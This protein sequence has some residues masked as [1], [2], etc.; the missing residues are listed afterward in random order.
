MVSS[1]YLLPSKYGGTL[2][3]TIYYQVFETK[4][5]CDAESLVSFID[6]KMDT[7]LLF[8]RML[9]SEQEW[10]ASLWYKYTKDNLRRKQ[11][12]LK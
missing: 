4:G 11:L 7:L 2:V 9:A 6:T 3:D 5:W 10:S 1:R 8:L 12:I